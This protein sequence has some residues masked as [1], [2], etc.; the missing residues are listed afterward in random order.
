MA[1]TFAPTFPPVLPSKRPALPNPWWGGV[2][3]N[4][5]KDRADAQRLV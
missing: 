4:R 3:T 5:A 1:G 2:T